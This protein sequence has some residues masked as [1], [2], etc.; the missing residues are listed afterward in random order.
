MNGKRKLLKYEVLSMKYEKRGRRRTENDERKMENEGRWTEI[1]R[2]NLRIF[3]DN[4]V[5]LIEY[6]ISF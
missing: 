1:R 5:S 4:R 2:G 6:Y 3:S